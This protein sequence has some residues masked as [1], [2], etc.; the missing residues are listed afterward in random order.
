[1]AFLTSLF[2]TLA[3]IA[4]YAILKVRTSPLFPP[5]KSLVSPN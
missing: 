2:Y 1:M 3:A 4:T 5:T